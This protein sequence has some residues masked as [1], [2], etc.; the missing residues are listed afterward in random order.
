MQ[1]KDIMDS[2]FR[3]IADYLLL[4]S[5]YMYDIGLFHGKMG[6]VVT[7]YMYAEKFH[8][9]LISEYAWELFQ[10][11]YDGIHSNMPI[12]LEYGL[13]GIG[14]GTTLMYKHGLVDCDLNS[15]L[16]EIDSK[17]MEY[18]PRRMK[19]VSVRS[20]IGGLMRYIALRQSTG[21]PLGTFDEQY[22]AELYTT[23]AG[24]TACS[25]ETGI[26]SILNAPPFPVEEYT[27]KPLGI[28]G[29][30]AYY[31]LKDILE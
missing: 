25:N 26:M 6:V 15:I 13:V 20:G 7:L 18:D 4:H 22:L 19:D 30:S 9:E 29:G 28:D 1:Q 5:P 23:A 14:Y 17:I 16:A 10:H 24:I 12:G 21:E 2:K 27:E 8:D 11:I 3:K 31:I